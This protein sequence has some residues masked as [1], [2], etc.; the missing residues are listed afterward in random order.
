[1]TSTAGTTTVALL[2][3]G[4]YRERRRRSAAVMTQNRHRV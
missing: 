4:N 1:M 3:L 2:S